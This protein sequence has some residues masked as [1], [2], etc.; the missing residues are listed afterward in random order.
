MIQ[1]VRNDKMMLRKPF[2]VLLFSLVF[3]GCSKTDDEAAKDV[4]KLVTSS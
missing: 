4:S 2:F 1:F 3:V